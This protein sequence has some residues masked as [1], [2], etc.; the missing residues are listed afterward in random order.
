MRRFLFL[1]IG[2]FFLF[3]TALGQKKPLDNAAL[4]SWQVIKQKSISDDGRWA[5]VYSEPYRGDSRLFIVATDG[6]YEHVFIGGKQA[7]ISSNSDYIVFK[8][9][10]RYDTIRKLKIKKVK[11]DKFPKDSA[12]I[13]RTADRRYIKFDSIKSVITPSDGG[14]ALALLRYYPGKQKEK[15]EV[16]RLIVYNAVQDRQIAVDSVSEAS[17]SDNGKILAYAVY[18]KAGDKPVFKVFV[19]N[20]GTFTFRQVEQGQGIA[21]K[22]TLSPSA[23]KLAYLTSEDTTDNK[24]YS[25]VITD[26]SSFKPVVKLDKG[27]KGFP[28]DWSVSEYGD[29]YFSDNG[30]RLFFGIAPAPKPKEDDTIPE[31]EKAKLDIWSWTDSVL[32]PRQ[33]VNLDKDK[34]F[35]YL[36]LYDFSAGRLVRVQTNKYTD[37]RLLDKGNSDFALERDPSPYLKQQSWDYPWWNDYYIVDLRTGNK[38]LAARKMAEAH[39]APGGR[40]VLY[41]SHHDSS[42]YAFDRSSSRTIRLTSNKA[43]NFYDEENDVPAPADPYGFGGFSKDGRF[44]YVYDKYD[45]WKLDMSGREEPVCLT[46]LFGRKH[47]I[48]LR[49]V[50]LKRDDDYIDLPNLLV[51]GFD[52]ITKDAGFFAISSLTDP[53]E[54]KKL[55]FTPHYYY[56][57]VKA[58]KANI[59]LW[60]RSDVRTY[61]DVWSATM[62][63]KNMHQLTN[64][65]SQQDPYLWA[66]VEL[67]KWITTDGDI[68]EGLLFKPD[69]FDPHKKYPMI[70]YYYELYSDRLH[71]Y[72]APTPSRS[73]INPI[74]YASNGY[75]V[76]IPNIRY[77][78]GFPGMS[79]YNYVISG[80]LALLERYPWIDRHH[81]GLQGQSW[82]GYE[83]AYIITQT[84]L[85]AAAEAGAPVSNM[86]S[87]YGGIRWG[88]G[89][90]RMFQYEKTQ[91]RIGKNLWDGLPLY[92]YNSPL[93]FVPQIQT[94]LLIMHNDDDGAVPWYQGIELFVAMRR[95]NKPVWL[96]NYN[97]QPHNLKAKSPACLDLTTRMMQFFD[98]YLKE[99]PMPEWMRYGRPAI[100]KQ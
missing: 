47:N 69:N 72:F 100:E 46:G 57:P 24:V 28:A 33:L 4:A 60:Q 10:P 56:T 77:K 55:I 68:E 65:E 22:I 3:Y 79:A 54:P 49:F 96:L 20:A 99:K 45:I 70:V 90:S 50:D 63:F 17:F 26:L 81:L 82:G 2:V 91:S 21:K 18:S 87:A 19:M 30:K 6:S 62:D 95:L 27:A 16:Y 43:V 35:S 48:K 40:F 36:T 84:N 75:L 89:L 11:K 1:W 88:S 97:G 32:M 74:H 38:I 98:H 15:P 34:K 66:N 92:I 12:Y 42:W 71:Y 25:L 59:I 44:A 41:Y 37:V 51:N 5:A 80:T 8:V 9:S 29:I 93:F 31:D 67:V 86:T 14:S 52:K 64:L 23:D 13:F 85:F 83:T 76:F 73:I 53:S 58:R 94:P 39:L 78:V 7:K 61:P